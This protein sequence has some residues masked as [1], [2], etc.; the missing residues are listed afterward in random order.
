MIGLMSMK[1]L[2]NVKMKSLLDV[3][4]KSL[5]GVNTVGVEACVS[6]VVRHID[7]IYHLARNQAHPSNHRFD[8]DDHAN[9]FLYSYSS[10]SDT[11]LAKAQGLSWPRFCNR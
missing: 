11:L 4:V 9:F 6:W 2:L 1:S 5:L 10:L 8:A 7:H 3:N